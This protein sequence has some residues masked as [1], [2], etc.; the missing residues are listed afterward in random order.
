MDVHSEILF[1]RTQE[2]L[3]ML[4]K[5]HMKDEHN[6]KTVSWKFVLGSLLMKRLYCTLLPIKGQVSNRNK[7]PF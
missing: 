1:E 3:S 6:W 4:L 2:W 7:L 5:S